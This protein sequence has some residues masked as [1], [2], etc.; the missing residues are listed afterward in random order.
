MTTPSTGA[1]RSPL[2][3]GALG[4]DAPD[5]TDAEPLFEAEPLAAPPDVVAAL[6]LALTLA[7]L[8]G[9]TPVLLLPADVG[10]ALALSTGAIVLGEELGEE[11]VPLAA[12]M[13][14]RADDPD[15]AGS[16]GSV[17][18]YGLLSFV[19]V[20]LPTGWILN[21][22]SPLLGAGEAPFVDAQMGPPID[23]DSCVCAWVATA[24]DVSG[25]LWSYC[26]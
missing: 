10:L 9:D 13:G 3:A 25:E 1:S 6:G 22:G 17:M 18:M 7:E 20:P 26:T 14:A 16:V 24:P 23:S 2:P 21:D 4:A 12:E 11:V 15:S 19:G 5:E 8:E